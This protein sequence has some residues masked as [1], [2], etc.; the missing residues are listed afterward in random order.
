MESNN[1]GKWAVRTIVPEEVYTDRV[2]F[3]DS[4]YEAALKPPHLQYTR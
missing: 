2:E 1:N 4:F 3:L